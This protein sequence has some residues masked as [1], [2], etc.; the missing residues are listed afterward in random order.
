MKAVQII[1]RSQ[2]VFVDAPRPQLRPG[3]A[4]IKT[5][6]LSLCG[7]DIRHL[8]YL[9]DHRYP[10]QPGDTGHEMVGVID[11]IDAP[12]GS[13]KVGDLV[14][15]LAPDHRAMAE[16]YLAPVDNLLPV[17]PA[18][19][20]EHS[21][22]AQQLGTVLY[23]AQRLPDVRG[24]TVAVIGQGSAGLYFNAALRDRGAARIIALD[25][26]AYRL[27][28]SR[29]F[30]ATHTIH[31]R[32]GCVADA[33]RAAND[34]EL[35]D[36]VVDAA[37]EEAAIAL[38]VD[39]VREDGFIL[40]FGVPRAEWMN[41]PYLKFFWKTLSAKAIVHATRDPDHACTRQALEWIRSG[42]ID[43]AR[44]ITHTFAFDQV[45]DAYELHHLQDEGAVKIVIDME[46]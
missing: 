40:L 31:N 10:T 37:G 2:P 23:A 14:L 19:P 27:R 5:L 26:K 25:L 46:R 6:R 12:E 34:G 38:A 16:Y 7:S 30:G 33:L 21:V 4:L 13:F 18:V 22:Q 29:H 17:D 39:I 36:I 9:P 3:H 41:F 32:D 8:H 43:V 24:Q 28:Y 11:A 35:P 42:K 15:A 44:M 20:L 45:M 1:A